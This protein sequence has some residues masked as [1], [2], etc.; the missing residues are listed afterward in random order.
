MLL[1]AP[2][3]TDGFIHSNRQFAVRD[4]SRPGRY[5]LGIECDGVARAGAHPEE[6]G[7]APGAGAGAGGG[8]GLPTRP[9][10]LWRLGP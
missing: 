8:C 3:L 9:Y 5:V 10:F 2:M 7:K 4:P 6:A 1:H